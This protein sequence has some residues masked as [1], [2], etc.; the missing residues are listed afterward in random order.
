MASSNALPS[1]P[2]R[3]TAEIKEC[4]VFARLELYNQG[5]PCGPDTV[6]RRLIELEVQPMPSRSAIAKILAKECLTYG[7][8][9]HYPGEPFYVNRKGV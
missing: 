1:S 6:R 5:N 9:G 3:T 2:F 7:R 4:V 8:T